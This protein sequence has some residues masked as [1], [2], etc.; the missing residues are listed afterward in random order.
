[1]C[2]IIYV[3]I[4]QYKEFIFLYQ[5]P[6]FLQN[7]TNILSR[8]LSDISHISDPAPSALG[9]IGSDDFRVLSEAPDKPKDPSPSFEGPLQ[10]AISQLQPLIT[11]GTLSGESRAIRLL[12]ELMSEGHDV[13]EFCSF[14][15]Q[16]VASSDAPNRQLGHIF[17]THYAEQ[18]PEASLLSINR[19]QKALN[20]PDAMVPGNALRALSSI[21]LDDT[22]PAVQSA[23]SNAVGDQSPYVKK[24]AA[25]A[26]IK[27]VDR[28]PGDTDSYLPFIERLLT[29]T[30]PIAFSGVIA[31]Y[32]SV[33]PVSITSAS[34]YRN[35]MN[36]V[37][38]LPSDR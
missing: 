33:C 20:A 28:S 36:G 30:S 38:F 3:F 14:A 31:A 11:S 27:A 18:Q 35:L 34:I 22:L 2:H 6:G 15:A 10:T 19:F 5:S 37:S 32:W 9:S 7:N 12:I 26:I 21:R 29:D 8:L 1:M 4:V 23:I 17:L 16:L 24:C 13:G 25:Y